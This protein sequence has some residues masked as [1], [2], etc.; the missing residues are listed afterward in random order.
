[1]T[2]QGTY[3]K[4]KREKPRVSSAKTYK[5]TTG[6]WEGGQAQRTATR[7][8]KNYNASC[9][10]DI[11]HTLAPRLPD[12]REKNVFRFIRSS[13]SG[14]QHFSHTTG[15]H[16]KLNHAT[17]KSKACGEYAKEKLRTNTK[18]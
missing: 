11:P 13:A 14:K 7:K 18:E 16:A 2:P 8:L 9:D 4:E 6:G 10:L 3:N 1:M 17:V 15:S 12:V 5:P